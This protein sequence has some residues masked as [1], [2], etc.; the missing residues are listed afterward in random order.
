MVSELDTGR[1]ASEETKPQREWTHG[2]VPARTLD[3]IDW[4]RERVSAKTLGFE[5]G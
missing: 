2:G 5:G 3:H 4:R 1:C